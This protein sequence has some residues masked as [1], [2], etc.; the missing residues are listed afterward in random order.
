MASIVQGVNNL[1]NLKTHQYSQCFDSVQYGFYSARNKQPREFKKLTSTL[2]A[3]ILTSM[4]SIM[5]GVNNRGNFKKLTSTLS[6][7]ILSSMASIVQG[8]NNRGNLKNSPVL[9]VL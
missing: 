9:S 8:V 4:A 5:Q 6:A 7:L 1:G 2:G 3:L